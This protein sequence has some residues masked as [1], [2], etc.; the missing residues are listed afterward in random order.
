MSERTATRR[1]IH[2]RPARPIIAR[3][4]WRPRGVW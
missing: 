1:V 2:A 4:L 3:I